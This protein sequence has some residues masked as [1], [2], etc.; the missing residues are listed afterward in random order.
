MLIKLEH[1]KTGGITKV[2]DFE[3]VNS[4]KS[5][6]ISGEN[7]VEVIDEDIKIISGIS[8]YEVEGVKY[9][10]NNNFVLNNNVYV[11]NTNIFNTTIDQKGKITITDPAFSFEMYLDEDKILSEG[12]NHQNNSLFYL[13]IM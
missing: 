4:L 2:D 5:K 9:Q 7:K 11:N 6:E 12:A 8:E 3:V 10:I 13:D 1:E